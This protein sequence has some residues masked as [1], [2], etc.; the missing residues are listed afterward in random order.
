METVKNFFSSFYNMTTS[1]HNWLQVAEP[2]NSRQGV[3]Q[4]NKTITIDS[5]QWEYNLTRDAH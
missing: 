3:P 5:L 4:H 2:L 1:M